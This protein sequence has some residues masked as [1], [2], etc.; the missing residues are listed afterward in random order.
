M[1]VDGFP[2]GICARNGLW[3]EW[4]GF[5]GRGHL[6]TRGDRSMKVNVF[7]ASPFTDLKHSIE[8]KLSKTMKNQSPMGTLGG[9]RLWGK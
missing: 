2:M 9:N 7:K 3:D 8:R 6:S 1:M 4:E 5:S